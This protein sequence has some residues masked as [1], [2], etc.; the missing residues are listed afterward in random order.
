S[1]TNQMGTATGQGVAGN[2]LAGG[3]A[4]AGGSINKANAITGGVKAGAN[5]LL[6]AMVWNQMSGGKLFS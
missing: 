3:Q 5:T 2:I 6:D 4:Q 1:N